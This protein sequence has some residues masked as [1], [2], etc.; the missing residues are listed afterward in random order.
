MTALRDTRAAP[1]GACGRKSC[2]VWPTKCL[3][4]MRIASSSPVRSLPVAVLIGRGGSLQMTRRDGIQ[5]ENP[6][7]L[8]FQAYPG[9]L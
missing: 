3:A 1:N 5:K 6:G 7:N 4:W 2:G 9:F 8:P